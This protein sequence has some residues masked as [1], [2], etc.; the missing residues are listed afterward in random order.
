MK[1]KNSVTNVSTYEFS[2]DEL[3][4]ILTE[5]LQLGKSNKITDIRLDYNTKED[6]S[7]WSG[8]VWDDGPLPEI[9]TGITLTIVRKL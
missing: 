5:Y 1:K 4:D 7:A 2:V 9:F 3:K 8:Q 6:Y